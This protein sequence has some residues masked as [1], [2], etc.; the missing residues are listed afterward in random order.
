MNARLCAALEADIQFLCQDIRTPKSKHYYATQDYL[1]ERFRRLGLEP[2]DHSFYVWGLGDCKNIFAEAGDPSKPRI[3]IGAHYE[4][5]I[6]SGVGADDNASACAVLLELMPK[7]IADPKH[8]YVFVFF[9]MEENYRLFGLRGSKAFARWY[10][11]SL[12][13]VVILDLVG[14]T[15]APGFEKVFLQFGPA[16]K[17]LTQSSYRFLH[18][19]M[20][21]V[22]PLG[23]LRSH[24][25]RSDYDEFRAR[26]I[27]H[28]FISSGTPW[29]YHTEHDT[30][31]ILSYE[32]MA[33]L[34][35]SLEVQIISRNI[36]DPQ[37]D[38]R[39]EDLAEFLE[40][41]A[42]CEKLRGPQIQKLLK[43]N[44]QLSRLD[45]IFLYKEIL[46]TLRREKAGLWAA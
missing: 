7:L 20:K 33:A 23:A 4:T 34:A 9:D 37:A 26:G 14:G 32:K 13:R 35:E 29:Y 5:R 39:V 11:P 41:F 43:K 44:G 2:K 12:D 3:L 17:P 28:L 27:P 38:G 42:R 22:E 36:A 19:P 24:G 46:P 40:I 10:Q 15:L 16:Y 18:L 31:A 8:S 21:V 45:I 25:A 1:R 6:E 30:P